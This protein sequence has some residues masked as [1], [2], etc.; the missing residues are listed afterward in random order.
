MPKTSQ[1]DRQVLV[2]GAGVVGIAC[3]IFLRRD[4]HQVTVI[5]R[6]PPGEGCSLGNA[7]ILAASSCVPL[8]MPGTLIRVPKW[9]LDPLGPLAIRWRYLPRLAPW[10]VRFVRAGA[11]ARV[12]A[13]SVALR[14]LLATTVEGHRALAEAAGAADLVRP[15]G[16]L[17][18]YE[19][20]SGFLR[21]AADWRLR[22]ARGVRME[23]L[24]G[25]AVGEIEPALAPHCRR[26]VW[27]PDD[28]YVTDPLG[29][30]RALAEHFARA[31]GSILRREARDFELGPE[32]P[33]R[34][35][36]DH[37]SLEADVFVIAAGAWSGELAARLGSP[38]PLESE[39]GYH[40]MIGQPGVALRVPVVA[41]ERMFGATPMTAGL[42]LAGTVEFGGL[43]A[44]PNYA[45]ARVLLRHGRRLLPGL[46]AE[47]V[48]E[49]MGHR[50]AL[51][52]SLPVIGRSPR[53][54]S[55]FFAFGHGHTGLTAAPMTGR[56]IA[57]LVAGRPP[58]FDLAPFAA[59]RF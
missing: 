19:T 42:R 55:V 14:S 43:T 25:G 4:G 23:E 27:L 12:E 18:A 2:I 10:L 39:R 5:D 6:L 37:G 28:G 22:R 8:S 11:P 31:G 40:V 36:T 29:L 33:T 51:P 21:E 3:A 32:G 47:A 34:L 44:P 35:A 38:V 53:H 45:R 46:K 56:V 13:A 54:P 52:D 1:G 7:G 15:S 9:L 41:G 17:W 16:L 24:E 50:P 26:A 20:A 30:V 58:P 57:D 48:S 59:D 49:W